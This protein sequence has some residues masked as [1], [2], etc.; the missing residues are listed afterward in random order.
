[1]PNPAAIPLPAHPENDSEGVSVEVESDEVA[2][3]REIK[4]GSRAGVYEKLSLLDIAA[5]CGPGLGH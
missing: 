2:Q 4:N 3:F 5:H 1:M